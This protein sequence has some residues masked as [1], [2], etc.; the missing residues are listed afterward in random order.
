MGRKTKMWRCAGCSETDGYP[1]VDVATGKSYCYERCSGS[2]T[3][4]RNYALARITGTVWRPDP[5]D[6]RDRTFSVALCAVILLAFICWS[7]IA[8]QTCSVRKCNSP[9]AALEDFYTRDLKAH[10]AEMQLHLIR[11]NDEREAQRERISELENRLMITI[12]E[13][14]VCGITEEHLK[15]ESAIHETAAVQCMA[16]LTHVTIQLDQCQQ[17]FAANESVWDQ[18]TI[19]WLACSPPKLDS[20]M[21]SIAGCLNAIIQAENDL[22][23]ASQLLL[24]YGRLDLT[25]EG[26]TIIEDKLR[27]YTNKPCGVARCTHEFMADYEREVDLH[28]PEPELDSDV[29]WF[30]YIVPPSD[31]NIRLFYHSRNGWM[32]PAGI[33]PMPPWDYVN[34]STYLRPVPTI[35]GPLHSW[36]HSN[37]WSCPDDRGPILMDLADLYRMCL[38]WPND[39]RCPLVRSV[40]DDWRVLDEME[41][42]E[43]DNMHKLMGCFD[44]RIDREYVMPADEKARLWADH[45]MKEVLAALDPLKIPEGLGTTYQTCDEWIASE[46]W[47][48]SHTRHISMT[49][50]QLYQMCTQ[51]PWDVRCS[52]VDALAKRRFDDG[53]RAELLRE[54]VAIGS[55]DVMFCGDSTEHSDVHSADPFE[56][57]DE[58]LSRVTAEQLAIQAQL[59]ALIEALCQI[60]GLDKADL[61]LCGGQ[62]I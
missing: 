23:E 15:V 13:G 19:L 56:E 30:P 51:W 10:A 11:T 45:E 26:R 37:K 14:R 46:M 22:L 3:V 8:Y 31:E 21:G 50:E 54:H 49:L 20:G 36:M 52:A 58:E 4:V 34:P 6:K 55:L 28:T 42:I 7:T 60:V 1:M 32:G 59:N 41:Y 5:E 47:P 57:L 48:C 39:E 29:V 18:G 25:M 2:R 62:A 12:L 35:D 33:R 53:K 61:R 40:T 17:D 38:H 43:A 16:N 9:L 44:E 27:C 24:Y